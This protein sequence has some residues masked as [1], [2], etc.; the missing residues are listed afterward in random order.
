MRANGGSAVA[1]RQDAAV[2]P[3]V[4]ALFAPADRVL[5]AILTRQAAR[6]GDR[7]LFVSGE[8]RWSYTQTAAIAA[9]SARRLI[10]AGIRPGDRVALLCSNR[11]EFLQI[12]LGCAWMGAV[13]VP[14]NTALR[15]TQLSH[16]FRNSSPKL[17]VVEASLLA[18]IETLETSVVPPERIW[19]IGEGP[20]PPAFAGS[21][22]R[23]PGA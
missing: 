10:E 17:L 3:R 20:S 2:W 11:P 21:V 7:T 15:G 6:Y 13:T 22:S 23:L 19:T 18:A 9:A 5:S 1:Q 8:T 16:I 4:P 14:I 12:Y